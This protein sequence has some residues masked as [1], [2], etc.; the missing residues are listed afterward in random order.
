MTK[1]RR[2]PTALPVSDDDL[3][4]GQKIAEALAE[5]FPHEMN[6]HKGLLF[7]QLKMMVAALVRDLRA[8]GEEVREK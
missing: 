7:V 3:I 1:R 5:R 2:M 4:E 6:S 8:D